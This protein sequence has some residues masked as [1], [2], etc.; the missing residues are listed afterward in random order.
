MILGDPICLKKSARQSVLKSSMSA[1]EASDEAGHVWTHGKDSTM[2][3]WTPGESSV[4]SV[5]LHPLVGWQVSGGLLF[6]TVPV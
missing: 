3:D 6:K 4:R 5:Y 2:I 1:L